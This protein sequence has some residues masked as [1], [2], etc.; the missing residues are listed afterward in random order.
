MRRNQLGVIVAILTFSVGVAM[1]SAYWI[2][3]RIPPVQKLE[4]P[5]ENTIE[6]KADD[7]FPGVSI[8]ASTAYLPSKS[9]FPPSAF[10]ASPQDVNHFIVDWY[11]KH[12]KAMDEPVLLKYAGYEEESYRFLWLRSF[13]HPVAVRLNRFGEGRM[14]VVKELDGA[15]GYKP[16]YVTVEKTRLLSEGEWAMF[17]HLLNRACYWQLATEDVSSIDG[18]DGAQWILEGVKEGRYHVVDRWS[19]REGT[20]RDACLYLLKISGLGIDESSGKVY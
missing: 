20:Y 18:V 4:E 10:R 5:T 16:G 2:V 6:L 14:L 13:H 19:P 8:Q 15:G 7:C 12:L 1:A 3:D 9:Y 11:S 17:M